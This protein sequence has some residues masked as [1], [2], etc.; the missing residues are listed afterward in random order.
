[1]PGFELGNVHYDNYLVNIM[2]PTKG[3]NDDFGQLKELNIVVSC[4]FLQEKLPNFIF[5]NMLQ[6]TVTVV[7]VH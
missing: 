6:Y 5:I 2:L 3:Y 7:H 4:L 1:M